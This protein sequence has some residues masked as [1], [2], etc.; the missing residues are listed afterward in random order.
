MQ[1]LHHRDSRTFAKQAEK[2]QYSHKSR[3]SWVT[4]L[5]STV[6]QWNTQMFLFESSKAVSIPYVESSYNCGNKSCWNHHKIA[7]FC[8][9][10]RTTLS[11]T[12]FHPQFVCQPMRRNRKLPTI[13]VKWWHRRHV[14]WLQPTNRKKYFSSDLLEKV[15]LRKNYRFTR[16]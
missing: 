13:Q 3:I 15:S 4:G 8:V 14:V 7:P 6:V 10:S 11:Q 1:I 16:Q 12:I 2:V 9:K 5:V